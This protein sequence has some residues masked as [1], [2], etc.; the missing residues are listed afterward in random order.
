MNKYLQITKYFRDSIAAKLRVDFKN[1]HYEIVQL[2]NIQEGIIEEK[3]FINLLKNKNED[4]KKIDVIIV[5]KTI[6]TIFVTQE[7]L[8]NIED[9][10]GIFFIPAVL[11]SDGT[12]SPPEGKFPWIPRE[13]LYPII[14]EKLAIGHINDFDVYMNDNHQKLINNSSWNVYYDFS[15]D[16]YETIT[17]NK[18]TNTFVNEIELD[19]KVYLLQDESII[20]TRN[21]LKLYDHLLD[22]NHIKSKLYQNFI[23]QEFNQNEPLI[24][25][26]ISAMKKHTAQMG[27]EYPLSFSQRECV[28]HFNNMKEGEILAVN[29][30]PGTGKT[31][32]LQSLVANLYVDKAIRKEKAPLIVASSTNNQAVTNI[33]ESFGKIDKKW[34]NINIEERWIEGVN[35]FAVYFPSKNKIKEADQ[36]GFQHTNP[37][38]EKFFTKVESEENIQISKVKFLKECGTYFKTSF[39]SLEECEDKI[40]RLLND[41]RSMNNEL[42]SIFNQFVQVSNREKAMDTFLA[43]LKEE[44]EQDTEVLS[45]IHSRIKDWNNHYKSIPFYYRWLSFIPNFKKKI[46][47]RNRLSILPQ[48]EFLD[49]S[50]NIEKIIYIYSNKSKEL[51]MK[52]QENEKLYNKVDE[53]NSKFKVVIQKLVGI[54]IIKDNKVSF[55]SIEELNEFLDTSL[56]YVSF[57]LA[58]HYYECRWIKE[59]R[60]TDGQKGKNYKNVLEQFYNNLS[61][62]TPCYVMTFFQLPKLFLAYDGKQQFLY[63]EI[64]LLIVDEAGQVTPEIAACSFSLAKRAVV[65]GDVYQIEPVWNIN[66]ALDVSL[67]IAAGVIKEKNEFDDLSKLGL[68]TSE[69]SVM[70]IACKCCNYEK[71]GERGL[72]LSE[73]RRC[74]DEIIEYCNKLVYKGNLEPK[75]GLGKNDKEYPLIGIS[76]PHFGHIQVDSNQSSKL[77]GSRYNEKEAEAIAKWLS[78]YFDDI[79]RAYPK[80]D[81]KNL[82]GIVTPFKMQV[83][84]IKKSLPSDIKNFV[85]VGTVHTFQGGERRV[86]IMSTVY[87]SKD[88]CYFMDASKSL[89]NVAISR[90]K[91]SFIV[92]GELGC[93]SESVAAPSGLL[94]KM[95]TN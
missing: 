44:I 49:E 81:V 45:R 6:K 32:L 5:A 26:N 7:K 24:N 63:N 33:I 25:N 84:K 50:M 83:S 66:K 40:W 43:E 59:K 4:T 17:G 71:F 69:S 62:V 39:N 91:D 31:T 55:N 35:S 15:K 89:L 52:L 64:D 75:R 65:V 90:A 11:N 30:P 2:E 74:Y 77:A 67:A 3:H 73:H 47:N 8:N 54:Q 36:K 28:N 13:H 79:K 9:F 88:G 70:K 14:E 18:I 22:G 68:N 37:E 48:E 76:I 61:M 72:F 80:E 10:T 93:L 34:K 51:R 82:I 78:K 19:N 60:L 85:D 56:R 29:G 41:V 46:I 57:W 38:G 87:G 92:I 42:L 53:L 58:V 21:I 1:N 94:K 86:I 16:M 23:K 95:L 20:A 27:G 12:L